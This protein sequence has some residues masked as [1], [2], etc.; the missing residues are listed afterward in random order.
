MAKNEKEALSTNQYALESISEVDLNDYFYFHKGE[1]EGQYILCMEYIQKHNYL[2]VVGLC[3]TSFFEYESG[4]IERISNENIDEHRI[5][6]DMKMNDIYRMDSQKVKQ[7]LKEINYK[8]DIYLKNKE[9]QTYEIS[10]NDKP[11]DSNPIFITVPLDD[12]TLNILV[13]YLQSIAFDIDEGWG[14]GE[15]DTVKLLGK[16]FSATRHEE[17]PVNPDGTFKGFCELQLFWNWEIVVCRYWEEIKEITCFYS[18]GLL[19]DMKKLHQEFE[20]K[21]EEYENKIPSLSENEE[22]ELLSKC[23]HY[24][25]HIEN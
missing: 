20:K 25:Q 19:E 9:V 15:D 22:L 12:F 18:D 3:E 14:I 11:K 5:E 21:C 4:D 7:K 6:M 1:K 2:H 17:H 13:A 23:Q 24:I 16:Y 8:T 10:F